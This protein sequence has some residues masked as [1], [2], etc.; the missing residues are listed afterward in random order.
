[1][2]GPQHISSLFGKDSSVQLASGP[3]TQ[4][5]TEAIHLSSK[6]STSGTRLACT[7]SHWFA[8]NHPLWSCTSAP[9]QGH[10]TGTWG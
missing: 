8:S 4:V 10:V 9:P 5:S 7:S 1:M 2:Q 3:H 6:R